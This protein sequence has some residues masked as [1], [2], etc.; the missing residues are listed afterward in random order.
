MK[1]K[2]TKKPRLARAPSASYRIA[3]CTFALERIA[4]VLE[5]WQAQR[6]AVTK[7]A[8]SVFRQLAAAEGSGTA[9]NMTAIIARA[10]AGQEPS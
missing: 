7:I 6:A 10:L 5:A 2:T 9:P 4:D 8:E 3:Q 1:K